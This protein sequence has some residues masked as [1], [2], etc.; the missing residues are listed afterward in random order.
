MTDGLKKLI[1]ATEAAKRK[2][3]RFQ[4]P[5]LHRGARVPG[6]PCGSV[7]YSCELHGGTTAGV[8]ACGKAARACDGC[9]DYAAPL[10]VPRAK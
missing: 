6:Q 1:A 4:L 5:C 2:G 8:G 7:L 10:S 9:P 3:Q